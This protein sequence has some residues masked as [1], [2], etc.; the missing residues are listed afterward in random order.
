MSHDHRPFEEWCCCRRDFLGALGA[1]GGLVASGGLAAGEAAAQAEPRKKQAATV[2]CVFLYPPPESLKKAGYWSWPGSGFDPVARQ[3]DYT[4]RL[5]LIEQKL[6]IRLAIDDKPLEDAA[7]TG[8]FIAALKQAPPDALLL[9]PFQKQHWAYV[10]RIVEETKIPAVVLATLGVLLVDHIRQLH[11][12][13]G[14]YLVSSLDNLDAVEWGLTMVRTARRMKDARL[15]N[16]SGAKT[17]E[18]MVPGLGTQVRTIPH[19]RFVEQYRRQEITPP[20]RELAERYRTQAQQIVEP[21]ADDILDAARAC[22]ALRKLAEVEMADAM[23]ME[24][25]S[26]LRLPHQ[27]CPPCMGFMTLRDEGFPIG[28]QADLSATLTLMLIQQLFNR[29][30]FQQNASMDTEKNLYFGSHC[31]APTKMNGRQAAAEPYI[32]RSH[33]EAG[34]GCVPRVVF[35][36]GQE[37][38][39]AQYL[40]G[41]QP[42]MLLYTGKI[43]GCPPTP[44]TG[45]CRSSVLVAIDEVA[46]VCDVKGMHQIIFYGNHGKQLRAFCQLYGIPTVS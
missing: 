17:T 40:P 7:A 1:A 28:C 19:A 4:A 12:R 22:L 34:W 15:L 26:G 38:T 13:T 33:A 41:Q 37:V 5:R 46:D 10:T 20:V 25:L 21:T 2:R 9:V 16:I 6:G 43:A 36:A 18:S 23:M 30:G 35:K 29:P 45:G 14:T 8:R 44:P 42:Q 11:R 32:L 3:R 39:M 24:C 31:T 27:H